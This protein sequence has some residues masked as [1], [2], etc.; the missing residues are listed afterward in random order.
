MG[1]SSFQVGTPVSID[2]KPYV[3]ERKI[4][5]SLWQLKETKTGRIAE[6][7]QA[8]LEQLYVDDTLRFEETR[9]I[10]NSNASAY[11]RPA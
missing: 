11:F 1:T 10:L 4:D 7:T 9:P 5:D 3:I 2:K 8:Q 6:F